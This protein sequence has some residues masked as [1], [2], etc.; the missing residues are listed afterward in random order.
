MFS[1]TQG[2]Q[3]EETQDQ[4]GTRSPTLGTFPEP[5]HASPVPGTWM[6]EA[7]VEAGN[8]PYTTL[9]AFWMILGSSAPVSVLKAPQ[10]L[11]KLFCPQEHIGNETSPSVPLPH[12]LSTSDA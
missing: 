8:A 6:Q 10:P 1:Y 9:E 4:I 11:G 12:Q 2:F 3:G 5:C 7:K